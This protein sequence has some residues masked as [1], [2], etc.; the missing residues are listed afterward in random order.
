MSVAS[1]VDDR[2]DNA[3]LRAAKAMFRSDE[4][5]RLMRSRL[6]ITRS[7]DEAWN[8]LDPDERLDYHIRV[9]WV[10]KALR[11]PTTAM[12]AASVRARWCDGDYEENSL[13]TWEA[14]TDAA[15]KEMNVLWPEDAT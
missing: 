6:P 7:L 15:L 1:I 2:I 12:L 3:I 14:M 9:G 4:A 10:L 8:A 11:N 5:N 13:A